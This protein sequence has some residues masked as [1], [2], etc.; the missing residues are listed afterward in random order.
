MSRKRLGAPGNGRAAAAIVC[1]ALATAAVAQNGFDFAEPVVL[2]LGFEAYPSSV[3]AGYIDGD[4]WIDLVLSGRN[5]DGFA[6]IFYGIPGGF[7]PP[8]QLDMGGQTSWA[9]VR[10][11]NTS[12]GFND[13][14]LSHR[15]GL[16]RISVFP[17]NGTQVPGKPVLYPVG[18]GPQLLGAADLDGDLDLDLAV[19]NTGTFDISVL[20]NDGNGVFTPVQRIAVNRTA[21]SSASPTWAQFVDVDGDEHLDIITVNLQA[22]GTVSV[23]HNRGDGTFDT[24]VQHAVAGIEAGEAMTALAA[25]D[26]DGDNDV[27]LVTKVGGLSF[28]DRIVVLTND[29]TGSFDTAVHIQLQSGPW[30]ITTGD[31]DNDGHVD[32]VWVTHAFSS[33]AV[34][35]LRNLGTGG[36]DFGIP[37]PEVL[38]GGFPRHVIAFDIDGDTDLDVIV[39]NIGNHDVTVL[40][41]LHVQA[42]PGRSMP[43]R[44]PSS[45][46]AI[47]PL[48]P[49]ATL[50]EAMT[51][52]AEWGAPSDA[53]S[54]ARQNATAGRGVCGDPEAGDCFEPHKGP[55]CD[56]EVCCNLV[57]EEFAL[58]CL[59]DWDE[60]CADIA[61]DLCEPPP[62]CPAEGSCFESHE[63]SGC[64]DAVCCELVCGFDPF[65][66]GG[67]WDQLCAEEAMQVCGLPVCVLAPCS[68]QAT[69]EPESIDCDARVNDGCNLLDA[70]F[71]PITCN[72]TICGTTWTRF[73]RNTDWYE[74]VIDA[75]AELFWNVRAEFPA[76]IFI[77]NG[78]CDDEY[79]I[80]ASAFSAPCELGTV[81]LEVEPGTYYLY[82]AP[83]FES[84][85]MDQ[86]VG[87][88]SE[89]ELIG[90]GPYGR[91]YFATVNCGSGCAE[92]VNGNGSVGIEDM[93]ILLAAWGTDPGGPPDFDGDGNVGI[94][95]FL[96]LLA[97]WGT[98]AP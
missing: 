2:D 84:A 3:D 57:C 80:V 42:R 69:P 33:K 7:G 24:A 74:I 37:E 78:T 22:H 9:V 66:C 82:V 19:L 10:D 93:L 70:A 4:R 26:L 25:A 52:L 34:G 95:D 23:L 79:A 36:P 72:E 92:D 30:D 71:T 5:N 94:N 20:A 13:L 47:R 41:N 21:S 11:F 45:V 62:V 16:G 31:F 64:D 39:A 27:D 76:E 61:N 54:T 68:A 28:Q 43:V 55:G 50:A 56:D 85:G 40:E 63:N 81:R 98:C 18:R 14:V 75:P 91:R 65:C 77:V 89:G 51:R 35:F 83:G 17:G 38:L 96:T 12:D 15:S 1:L 44:R 6:V 88:L 49:P 48:T 60:S 73:N 59:L 8:V 87:C 53:N 58:C 46:R 67:P 90:G 29:G 32:I 97:A 86:G